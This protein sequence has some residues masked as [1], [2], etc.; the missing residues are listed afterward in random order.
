MFYS[1]LSRNGFL[2]NFSAVFVSPVILSQ[3]TYNFN[4]QRF[5]TE[6]YGKHI[7]ILKQEA[8]A[9]KENEDYDSAGKQKI[10]LKSFI[11][12]TYLKNTS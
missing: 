8:K 11:I 9:F 3:Q 1:I 7:Y 2:F 6:G 4:L 12:T 10:V 5:I